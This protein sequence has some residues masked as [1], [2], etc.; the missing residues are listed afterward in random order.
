MGWHTGGVFKDVADIET[1]SVETA[2]ARESEL[3]LQL[4]FAKSAAKL[5]MGSGAAG[6]VGNRFRVDLSGQTTPGNEAS[7]EHGTPLIRVE[8]YEHQGG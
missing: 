1:L 7:S 4:A 2:G 8:V 3:Q 5:L 6:K